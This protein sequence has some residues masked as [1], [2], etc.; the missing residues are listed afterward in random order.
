[1]PLQ[2]RRRRPQVRGD[3]RHPFVEDGDRLGLMGPGH[4]V[5][6]LGVEQ[7]VAVQRRLAGRRVAREH[8][9]GA[10]IRSAVAEDHR[11]DGHRGPEVV[12]DAL[13]LAIRLR[14]GTV[15]GSEHG[16]RREAELEPRVL[17]D[18]VDA[19]D[20][21]EAGDEA[22]AALPG[23]RVVPCRA[24]ETVGR[25][26]VEA[27]VQDRVH[28]PGHR[29][30][31]P[32]PD[33]HEQRVVVAAEA[34]TDGRFELGHPRSE[35]VVEARRPAAGEERPARLGRDDERRRDRQA[36]APAP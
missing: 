30:R 8:D 12:G 4:D 34:P 16:L 36:A 35:L 25:G 10:R 18:V 3:R 2:A 9:P 33:A 23:E 7:D 20:R 6:A 24:G 1:M 13:L 11:L 19:D 22:L 32:G 31:R 5:L 27:Q 21:P 15:P 28:H 29:D 26:V 17:G 14:A